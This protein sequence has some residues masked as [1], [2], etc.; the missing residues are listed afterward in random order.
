MSKEIV[1]VLIDLNLVNDTFTLN[2]S[3]VKEMCKGFA[4]AWRLECPEC[5]ETDKEFWSI[6]PTDRLIVVLTA[7]I[8]MELQDYIP[9]ETISKVLPTM[10]KI[11]REVIKACEEG[12]KEGWFNTSV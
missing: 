4:S 3:A 7:A 11:D 12:L 5:M 1:E 2:P 9:P 6:T 8:S 10:V